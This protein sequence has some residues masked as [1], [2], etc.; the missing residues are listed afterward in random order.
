MKITGYI[1]AVLGMLS[2]IGSIIGGLNPIGGI[3]FLGLGIF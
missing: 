3:L 1:L 2:T